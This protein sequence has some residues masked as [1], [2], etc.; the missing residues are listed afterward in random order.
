MWTPDYITLIEASL[1]L[2][3]F[4]A[5]VILAFSADQ[6]NKIMKKKSQTA[7]AKQ[8]EI[9]QRE[10]YNAKAELRQIADSKGTPYVLGAVT[11]NFHDKDE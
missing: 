11:K 3:F 5:L 10:R 9:R 4:V 8:E 2:F 1:T 7:E 6:V